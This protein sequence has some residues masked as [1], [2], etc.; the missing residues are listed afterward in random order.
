MKKV[1]VP[2]N[3]RALPSPRDAETN[4]TKPRMEKETVVNVMEVS[5]HNSL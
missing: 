2:V 3:M 1:L 5:T 4:Y